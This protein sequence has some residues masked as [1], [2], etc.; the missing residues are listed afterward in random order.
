MTNAGISNLAA[1]PS[2]RDGS[3]AAAPAQS[4]AHGEFV[5]LRDYLAS[6]ILG[7]DRLIER[8]LIALL[9]DGHLLV[10]G[11]QRGPLFHNLILTDEVNRAP[12]KVQ[13]ALLGAMAE[14]Q[15]SVTARLG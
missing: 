3:A 12:A 1:A 4:A 13:S 14:R 15:I 10:E 2:A 11:F 5:R 6:Q 9:A 8:L 7:Q